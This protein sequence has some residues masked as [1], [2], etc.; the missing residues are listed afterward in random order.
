[1]TMYVDHIIS[2]CESGSLTSLG[3]RRAV[4]F[5]SRRDGEYSDGSRTTDT[6]RLWSAII[7]DPDTMG[8]FPNNRPEC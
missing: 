7:F 2:L 5:L 1:M 8:D 4:P 6:E 3:V